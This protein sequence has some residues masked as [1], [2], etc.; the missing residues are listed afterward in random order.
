L[1][2]RSQWQRLTRLEREWQL[3]QPVTP[4]EVLQGHF[5]RGTPEADAEEQAFRAA[6]PGQNLVIVGIVDGRKPVAA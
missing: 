3:S 5:L 6:H 4:W 1:S 2:R